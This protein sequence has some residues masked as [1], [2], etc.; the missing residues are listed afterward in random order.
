VLAARR[1][2]WFVP[3]LAGAVLLGTA[4]ALTLTI[5]GPIGD[6]L[7]DLAAGPFSPAAER[8]LVML[9]GAGALLLAGVPPL[10]RVPWGVTL[11]PL[12]AILLVRVM[13]TGFPGGLSEW[14]PLAFLVLG[15]GTVWSGLR[16]DWPAMLAGGGL[17]VLWTGRATADLPGAILVL[18]AWL[19]ERFG[20]LIPERW[21][22]LPVVPAALAGSAGLATLLGTE[23]VLPVA[24][25]VSI[26]GALALGARRRSA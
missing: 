23:V 9:Y 11:A 24:A 13:G 20:V 3:L 19:L 12:A 10:R 16:R 25:T 17:L 15:A 18:T 7:D 21:Q 14:Q 26:A 6:R 1:P 4:L 5:L 2:A 22:G 8:M